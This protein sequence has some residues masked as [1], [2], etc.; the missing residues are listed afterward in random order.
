VAIA[1]PKFLL[2]KDNHI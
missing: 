1:M 2:E